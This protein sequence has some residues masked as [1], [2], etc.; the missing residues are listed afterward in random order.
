MNPAVFSADLV[1]VRKLGEGSFSDVFEVRSKSTGQSY[2][3]KRMK[4][5]YKTLEEV[6]QLP[7]ITTL[8]ALQDCPFVVKL[9]DVLFDFQNYSL[10]LVFEK[11]ELNL[12]E[13][14]CEQNRPIPEKPTLLIIYQVLRALQAMHNRYL[15]HRDIKPENCMIN[16]STMEVKVV[17]FGSTRKSSSRGPFTEY[18]STRW[19]RAPEILL[20]SGGYGPAVDVWAVGCMMYELLE[21]RPLFPGK[22]ELDQI[23]RIHVL[24]GT[25]S[26][27]LIRVFMQ[28]PNDQISYNFP[29]RRRQHIQQFMGQTSFLTADLLEDMLTYNPLDR[30]TVD[31]CL[32][33]PVFKELNEYYEQWESYGRPMP[34]SLFVIRGPPVAPKTQPVPVRMTIEEENGIEPQKQTET[35]TPSVSTL[36]VEKEKIKISKAD[37]LKSRKLAIERIKAYNKLHKKEVLPQATGPLLGKKSLPQKKPGPYKYPAFRKNQALPKILKFKA[38]V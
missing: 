38:A 6:K 9:H 10:A 8:T 15:F 33:H 19:Y 27:E 1:V 36:N 37:L 24:C 25:P 5:E 16:P 23:T 32:E 4:K 11:L 13:F 3:V 2:A 31:Q 26:K 20:T 18:V 14:L 30:I 17:D 29:Y 34:F 7:E 21:N 28:N 22:N 12:Y 35:L